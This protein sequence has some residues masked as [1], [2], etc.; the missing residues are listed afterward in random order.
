MTRN[1][2]KRKSKPG[3][4]PRIK[5]HDSDKIPSQLQPPIF[6][7]KYMQ[8]SHCI[9]AC[10]Q[11]EKASFA[12][13]LRL[14]SKMT[15]N[16]IYSSHRHGLGCEK[17]DRNSIKASI[18]HHITEDT[19]LI[20]FRFHGKAPMVGYRK[21]STFHIIWIDRDFSLYQH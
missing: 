5:S 3:K 9:T 21:E 12:D 2:K 4:E 20:A 17:I 10:E 7:L 16:Q 18:P 19:T 1:L 8:R 14:L 6:S 11:R 13:K 15:W